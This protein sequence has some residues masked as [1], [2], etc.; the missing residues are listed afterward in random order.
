MLVDTF[1]KKN[2]LVGEMW[3][4]RKHSLIAL[5]G[6]DGASSSSPNTQY[7]NTEPASDQTGLFASMPRNRDLTYSSLLHRH[8]LWQ[9]DDMLWTTFIFISHSH[10]QRQCQHLW[11]LEEPLSRISS[12]LSIY[13]K[14]QPSSPLA[15]SLYEDLINRYFKQKKSGEAKCQ[16]F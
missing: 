10:F 8:A 9:I 11:Y 2:F 12:A 5:L 15:R 3:N 14:Y 1:D 16:I 13:M 4:R 7:L 6:A